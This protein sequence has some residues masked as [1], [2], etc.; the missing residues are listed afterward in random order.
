MKMTIST[1][2]FQDMVS[3]S[4]KGASQNKLLPITSLIAI[5]LKGGTLSL[6][7][8]DTINYLTVM[9][10]KIEGDDMYVVVPVD[11]FS[12]LIAKTTAETITLY[13]TENSLEVKG[14]GVYSIPLSMDEEGVVKFPEYEFDVNGQPEIIHLSSIRNVIE[15]N[16]AAAAKTVDTPC[17]CGYYFG[18]HVITTDEQMIC[19]NS[20][21]VF[22]DNVLI[23]PEMM[24][25]LAL[26][27]E[28]KISCFRNDGFL[29]CETPS[30]IVYGAEHDGID[31]YPVD[32]I[33]GYLDVEFPSVC[34]LPKLLLQNVI[35]RLSLF[36]EPYDKNG[37]YFT[38]T[39]EGVRVTSKRSSSVEL[40]SYIS[41]KDFAPFI[42]CVD[43]PMFK[44]LVDVL[45]GE[46]IELWY[47]NA[48]AV[49]MTSGKITQVISLLEDDNLER[50][51][52]NE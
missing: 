20:M 46:E 50:N 25:L 4:A 16:K 51:S 2:K 38:F 42:C 49:K 8:T 22:K 44:S 23:S 43:I 10:D 34:K 28:E 39:K 19:F 3:K 41:S 29:F 36:I 17:L 40:I 31:L 21:Q 24:E 52:G 26:N 13:T 37:A 6:V 7:T 15:T 30:V 32:E 45:P 14:N 9:A 11:I 18:E 27:T 1:S 12:K 48:S 47:G 5:E 35:D 33:L